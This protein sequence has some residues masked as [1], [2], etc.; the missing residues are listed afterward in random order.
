M[1]VQG[2][3]VTPLALSEAILYE[4]PRARGTREMPSRSKCAPHSATNQSP[5]LWWYLVPGTRA[6]PPSPRTAYPQLKAQNGLVPYPPHATPCCSPWKCRAPCPQPTFSSQKL[7]VLA[8]HVPQFSRTCCRGRMRTL[9]HNYVTP[10]T[11]SPHIRP[12]LPACTRPTC[13]RLGYTPLPQRPCCRRPPSA[14]PRCGG[15]S[16]APLAPP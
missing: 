16:P 7:R 6:V 14:L 12:Y 2:A 1:W 5:R 10:A 15:T 9:A 13:L 3:H 4:S 11:P 8:H